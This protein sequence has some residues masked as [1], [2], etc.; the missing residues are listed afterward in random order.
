[1]VDM[2]LEI[3]HLRLVREVSLAGSLTRAGAVLHLTQ[4]ALSHQLRDIESRLDTPLFLRVGKR[5]ILTP[6][7][8]RLLRSADDV[9][10]TIEQTEEAIRRLAG[11]ERGL[12]RLTTECYTCYHWLPAL[13][14]RYRRAHPR[15]DVRID[16]TATSQPLAHLLD[17]RLDIAIVSDPVRDRRIVT[18]RLFDDEMVVIVEPRHPLAARPFV[19]A[20]DFAG[21]TLLTYSSKEDSTVYQR[22]L[23]PAGITPAGMQQV[24]LTEAMI[25]LVKAGLGVAVLAWW[26]VEPYVRAGAIRALPLTRRGYKRVWSA[27]T[28]KDLAQVPYVREFIDLIATHPPFT[29]ASARYTA[30]R[31]ASARRPSSRG[32]APGER[33]VPSSAR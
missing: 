26:A 8:E 7:G 9:L 18:E 23:V 10:T 24:Q 5:M 32:L 12:L 22:I 6:A 20:E 11:A 13:M 3:R 15:V 31:S 19:R 25:E 27:A 2:D 14:K 33:P 1:M 4:S 21:E 16:A 29:G 17:G 28:L 30:I